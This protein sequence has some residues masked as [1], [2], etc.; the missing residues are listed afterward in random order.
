[1]LFN[2]D[3]VSKYISVSARNTVAFSRFK[4]VKSNFEQNQPSSLGHMQTGVT[5]LVC[6]IYT[7][8]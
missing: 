3:T 5:K 8:H 6:I 4:R 1:M 7:S 2:V